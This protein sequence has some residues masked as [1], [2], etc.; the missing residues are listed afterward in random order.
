M[1]YLCVDIG[2][3]NVLIGI[4]GN[5][6]KE[7]REKKTVNFLKNIENE[8]KN[9]I[10]KVD[11]ERALVAAAGPIDKKEGVIYPPNL[12]QNKI[13]IFEPFENFFDRVDLINDCNAAALGEYTYGNTSTENLLY[14]TL[15]TGI[16]AGL[17]ADGS[18]IQGET[19]NF[20]EV[21]HMKI[22]DDGECGCGE[23]GHWEA[24]C[25]GKNIPKL[26]EREIDKRF[27][28]SK[29]F[30]EEYRKGNER[31]KVVLEKIVE[32]NA[33]A[34]S[35]LINLY[36]PGHISIGGSMGL[37]QFDL[38]VEKSK[39]RIKEKTIYT[40]PTIEKSDLGE[41][42]VLHGLRALADKNHISI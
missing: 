38:L 15:S 11:T 9:L 3:T 29:E 16:G 36:D 7:I 1:S 19:N 25:S 20:A 31:L 34:I 37:E 18:L 2:A 23:R 39:N 26:V 22:A 17:I 28:S 21:G 6:F 41:E 27:E 40:M 8:L 33:T 5:D 42:V 35:N 24:L 14:I 10:N 4:L 30:F 12:S 13:N 32:Y